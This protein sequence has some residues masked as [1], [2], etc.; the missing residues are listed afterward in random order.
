MFSSC[1]TSLQLLAYKSIPELAC[2]YVFALVFEFFELK[3]QITSKS[4][5]YKQQ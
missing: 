3:R 1:K 2:S 5:E 4:E